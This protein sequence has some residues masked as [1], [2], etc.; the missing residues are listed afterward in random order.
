MTATNLKLLLFAI[1][2]A[3]SFF[4]WLFKAIAKKRAEAEQQRRM[5]AAQLEEMRTGRSED[6]SAG[7]RSSP[8]EQPMLASSAASP[9]PPSSPLDDRQRKLAELRRR[10]AQR[11]SQPSGA[12]KPGSVPSAQVLAP[13]GSGPQVGGPGVIVLPGGVTIRVNSPQSGQVASAQP[14]GRFAGA[15]ASQP[16]RQQKQPKQPKQQKQPR[17]SPEQLAQ[18]QRQQAMARQP[19]PRPPVSR[20]PV[21]D[22]PDLEETQRLNADTEAPTVTARPGR[23]SPVR[24]LANLSQ[25]DLRTAFVLTQV[26][27]Q[28][29]CMQ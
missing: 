17:L 13:Q 12:P 27:G 25:R 18:Q 21:S 10:A 15:Q 4:S 28:P 23:K 11:S 3:F 14:A 19:V 5:R 29:K 16:N 22:T 2:I 9:Q 1:F 24:N 8:F 26:F 7:V 6:P 20:T